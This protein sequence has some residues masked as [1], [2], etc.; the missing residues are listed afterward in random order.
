[1]NCTQQHL[2]SKFLNQKTTFI[3]IPF[4]LKFTRFSPINFSIKDL[5]HT[6]FLA[7]S[8]FDLKLYNL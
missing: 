4:N 5:Y 1:M 8:V 3:L 6:I 2:T 7:F